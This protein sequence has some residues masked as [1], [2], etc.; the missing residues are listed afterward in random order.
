MVVD[1]D[2]FGLQPMLDPVQ[3]LVYHAHREDVEMVLVDGWVVVEAGEVCSLDARALI[4]P[5]AEAAD[6]VWLRFVDK[7]GDIIAR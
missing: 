7:Y 4:D 2:R 6:A 1:F 3:N 5:A